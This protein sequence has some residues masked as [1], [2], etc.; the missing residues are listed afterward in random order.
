MW[1]S[2]MS[3][4]V[5]GTTE[6]DELEK[7]A[8]RRF[9]MIPD[10]VLRCGKMILLQEG[11]STSTSSSCSD[12]SM[13]I[14]S[15]V[16]A[17]MNHWEQCPCCRRQKRRKRLEHRRITFYEVTSWYTDEEFKNTYCMDRDTFERLVTR[18]EP[19]L[20]RDVDMAKR[21]SAGVLTPQVRLGITLRLL[22]GAQPQDLML[23]FR[24]ARGSVNMVFRETTEA[25]C[26][27][28][29]FPGVPTDYNELR[30][31][32]H[33]FKTSRRLPNPLHGCIGAVDGIVIRV[34]QP[35]SD[36]GP[37]HFFN[38]K[39]YYAICAQVLVDSDYRVRCYSALATGS[40][41][42]SVALE[43]S[44]LGSF[45]RAGKLPD[46]FWIAGDNAY[47]VSETVLTPFGRSYARPGSYEDAF[48]YFLSSMRV[49]VEQAFGILCARFKIL[50]SPLA[51][52]FVNNLA[53]IEALLLLHNWCLDEMTERRQA[54]F[55][56]EDENVVLPF[57]DWVTVSRHAVHLRKL[58]KVLRRMNKLE[59]KKKRQ[60]NTLSEE[61]EQMR[62]KLQDTYNDML[63]KPYDR[64]HYEVCYKRRLL[65]NKL[66]EHG[67]VR[68]GVRHRNVRRH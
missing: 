43:I 60:R 37:R 35:E 52:E 36:Y 6:R 54:R 58:E 63:D 20:T 9:D 62:K 59:T 39:G 41:H 15:T 18:L 25:I 30:D 22:C 26:D 50:E 56:D 53:T 17:L 65:V 28:L 31:L 5:L 42:D 4:A 27:T 1:Y 47:A 29:K 23:L 19:L 14:E 24:V 7:E 2:K 49:H 32:A 64:E 21:S 34:R 3:R 8:M 11:S 68:P 33:R 57:N 46:V 48:N 45:L 61:Q 44:N 12:E 40:T 51:Y 16:I 67:L 10:S 55:E 66:Q 13:E 38:R